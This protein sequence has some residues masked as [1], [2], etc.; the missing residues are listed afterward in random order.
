MNKWQILVLVI[1]LGILAVVNKLIWT[2]YNNLKDQVLN[3]AYS[4]REYFNPDQ[5][6]EF[7]KY[8]GTNKDIEILKLGVLSSPN[9]LVDFQVR[10]KGDFKFPWSDV[11]YTNYGTYLGNTLFLSLIA[12]GCILVV[13]VP[14]IVCTASERRNEYGDRR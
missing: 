7:K 11:D 14:V 2:D 9:V 1:T 6:E 3:R 13:G 5:Y 4:G 12:S 10:G 8:L